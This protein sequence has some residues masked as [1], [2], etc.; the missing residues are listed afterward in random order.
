[1]DQGQPVKI[2]IVED[3]SDWLVKH[4]RQ[5]R[6][7]GIDNI[8]IA[9]RVGEAIGLIQVNDFTAVLTDGLDGLYY[10]IID[11]AQAKQGTRVIVISAREPEEEMQFGE[12]VS[13]AGGEFIKVISRFRNLSKLELA[14]GYD[15]NRLS[16]ASDIFLAGQEVCFLR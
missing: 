7:E 13:L 14:Y 16:K 15:P 8:T 10:K 3:Q 6:G 1:M 11:A 12:E 5:L 9:N 2:L 4:E